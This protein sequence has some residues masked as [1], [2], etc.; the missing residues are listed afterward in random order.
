MEGG[1][2]LKHMKIAGWFIMLVLYTAGPSISVIAAQ[3][4]GE[5]TSVEQTLTDY[6][7]N[8]LTNPIVVTILLAIATLSLMFEL[9]SPGF[10]V[11]GSIGLFSFALFFYG[12]FLAGFA[13]YE[14]IVLFVVGLT[15]LVA[16]L[17]V[18]GGIVGV[19]GVVLA[20]IGL[21]LAGDNMVYMAYSIVIATM[22]ACIGMVVLMKFFGKKLHVFHKLVLTDATTTED[23]YVSNV[24]R[25]E[26]LGCIAKTVTPLRPA[27]TV[28]LSQER[29]DVVSEGGY[30]EA[31][32]FVKIIKVE[33]SRIVVREIEEQEEL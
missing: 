26:L 4:H 1:L 9:F 16:E 15:L 27:G 30:V 8:F 12:H 20:V 32:K 14:S 33:G 19:I 5:A 6:M 25:T 7:V 17:F 18:P 24:N 28:V 3:Q 2:S 31:G 29:I 10:G 22:I 21:L 23:G 11:P 13:G